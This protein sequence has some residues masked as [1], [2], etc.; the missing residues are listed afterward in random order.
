MKRIYTLLILLCLSPLLIHATPVLNSVFYIPGKFNPMDIYIM[1]D[2]VGGPRSLT[3]TAAD[4]QVLEKARYI[5]NRNGR[6]LKEV[7]YNPDGQKQ[8]ETVYKYEAGLPVEEVLLNARSEVISKRVNEFQD[9][10]LI[11]STLYGPDN[12][13]ILRQRFAYRGSYPVSGSEISGSETDNFR[14]RIHEG[15]T[16]AFQVLAPDGTVSQD[17]TYHYDDEG[18]I[19]RRQRESGGVINICHYKYD[20]QGRIESYTYYDQFNNQT[21]IDKS[22]S[23]E[24]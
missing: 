15:R 11:T 22:L 16:L 2:Q 14:I 24:Y 17:I 5:Y 6:L 20:D 13:K 8:G 18:R 10:K 9:G 21:S 12:E 4:G 23:F 19:I 7:Y 3:V 1:Q